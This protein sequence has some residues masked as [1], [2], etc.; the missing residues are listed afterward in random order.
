MATATFK[1]QQAKEA[2][3]RAKALREMMKS[4]ASLCS[5]IPW[6]SATS[7]IARSRFS[8]TQRSGS[9]PSEMRLAGSLSTRL[10]DGSHSSAMRRGSLSKSFLPVPPIAPRSSPPPPLHS[11]HS[12]RVSIQATS[13]RASRRRQ[14]RPR[15][16]KAHS[17]GSP[18][19]PPPPR[20]RACW[21]GSAARPPRGAPPTRRAPARRAP[22]AAQSAR[23]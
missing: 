22:P 9:A 10:P 8:E 19:A 5:R 21:P 13:A 20:A 17:T 1:S 14:R 16:R 7:R 18:S 2:K 6:A 23:P 15:P 4:Q 3:S 11:K 12:E